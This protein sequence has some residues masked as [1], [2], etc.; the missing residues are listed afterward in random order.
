MSCPKECPCVKTDCPN[1]KK[2][3]ACINHHREI[4]TMPYCLFLDRDG[5]KSMKSLYLKLK[6]KFEGKA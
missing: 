1:H 2:C 5:E 3:C 6:G 4:E